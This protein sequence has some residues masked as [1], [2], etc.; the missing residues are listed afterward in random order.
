MCNGG[1]GM[2]GMEKR[3][4]NGKNIMTKGTEKGRNQKKGEKGKKN[5]RI[6]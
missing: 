5:K 2:G 4:G 3:E 1:E 6:K